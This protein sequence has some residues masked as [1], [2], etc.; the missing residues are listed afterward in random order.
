[1]ARRDRKVKI[2]ID[3]F[4][5]CPSCLMSAFLKDDGFHV[6]CRYC[7]WDSVEPYAI[8]CAATSLD[9]RSELMFVGNA[10]NIC[11]QSPEQQMELQI[12]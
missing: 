1:M 11:Q 6:F 2:P 10:I 8:A 5:K 4:P 9:P 12:A 3:A 7:R